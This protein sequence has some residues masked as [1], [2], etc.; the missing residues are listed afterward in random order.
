MREPTD[1][2]QRLREIMDQA[3]VRRVGSV[4]RTTKARQREVELRAKVPAPSEAN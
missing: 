2:L 3:R 1:L 4:S